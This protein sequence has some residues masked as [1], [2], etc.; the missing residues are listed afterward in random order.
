MATR[1]HRLP[2]VLR[3]FGRL[4]RVNFGRNDTKY[5]MRSPEYVR[6]L[7]EA[8]RDID[9]GRGIPLDLARLRAKLGG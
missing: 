8:K 2:T 3:E 9:E 5:I 6:M 4:R 7:R 1:E